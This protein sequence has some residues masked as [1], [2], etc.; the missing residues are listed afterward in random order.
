DPDR[1]VGG[2][3][4]RRAIDVGRERHT[5]VV[6]LRQARLLAALPLARLVLVRKDAGDLSDTVLDPEPQ[7]EYLPAAAVGQHRP[8][9]GH[10]AVQAAE[11]GDD[12]LSRPQVQVV[13]VGK[14]HLRTDLAQLLW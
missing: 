4:V 9:P 5:V 13:R 8:I 1:Y 14:D 7:A 12:V 3:A 10:E 6:D 11:M 2:E